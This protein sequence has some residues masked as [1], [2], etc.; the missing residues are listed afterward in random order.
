MRGM[1]IRFLLCRH[2]WH[3]AAYHH[4]RILTPTLYIFSYHSFGMRAARK[5]TT[6]LGMYPRMAFC[7]TMRKEH[8]SGSS[9]RMYPAAYVR[10]RIVSVV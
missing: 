10:A 6:S 1:E 2:L 5:L 7:E 9:E 4:F 3:S 8:E